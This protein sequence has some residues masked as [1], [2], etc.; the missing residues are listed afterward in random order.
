MGRTLLSPDIQQEL[1]DSDLLHRVWLPV[2]P[3]TETY[4]SIQC[5][6]HVAGAGKMTGRQ[7]LLFPS[8]TSSSV[9]DTDQ[10]NSTFLD[11]VLSAVPGQVQGDLKHPRETP[12]RFVRS[13]NS[14]PRKW[15]DA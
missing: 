7:D 11:T 14:C 13:E 6:R 2:P 5:A 1:F 3:P 8:E 9:C 4:W 15:C 12:N 10:L